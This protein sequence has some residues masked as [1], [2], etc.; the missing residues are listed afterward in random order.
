[1]NFGPQTSEADSFAIMDQA[2]A[3]GINF[4]DTANAYGIF[5]ASGDVSHSMWVSPRR[6]SNARLRRR[7]G[8]S[9]CPGNQGYLP[10]AMAP[11]ITACRPTTSDGP[12]RTAYAIFRPITSTSINCMHDARR[13]VREVRRQPPSSSGGGERPA[14]LG[15]LHRLPR[16][17]AVPRPPH[18]ARAAARRRRTARRFLN[19]FAYTG[20]ATVYAAAGGAR[21][22]TTVDMSATYLDWAQR[23]LAVNG[24]RGAEPRVHPGRLHRLAQERRGRAPVL[25]PDLPGS[26]HVL[27]QQAHGRHPRRA[28]RSRRADRPMHGAAAPGRQAGVLQ[29]RAEVQ[30]GRGRSASATR[31][32]TS[33]ARPMPKDF[34]RNPRIHQCFELEQAS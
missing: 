25:R 23:N 16:H 9:D 18:H 24:L 12:V 1:M 33:R 8:A 17:R 7:H 11:M 6:S 34:E 19:L 32:R 26:A 21:S 31:S 10:R 28:A 15:Q 3:E 29:Q 27:Q 30:A 4:I 13:A 14:I 22:T 5:T 20:S 2:L